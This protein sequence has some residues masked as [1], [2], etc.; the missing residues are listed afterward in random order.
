[1]TRISVIIGC[2][3]L[4]LMFLTVSPA[5]PC[6]TFMVS[7]DDR[8]IVAHNLDQEFYTPGMIHINRRAE[9]KRSIS[10]YDIGL[11]DTETPIVEWTSKYGSVTLSILG[12]NL[13]DGGMNE[14]GLTVSE[15]GLPESEFAFDISRPAMLSHLWIQYQLDSFATVDEV[16]THLSDFNIE[17]SSTFSP[18]ASANYHLFVTDR[19]GGVAIIEFLPGGPKIYKNKDVPVPILC[20]QTYEEELKKLDRYRGIVG[21]LK[22]HM[23]HREDLRFVVGALALEDYP[24]GTES[25]PVGFGFDVLSDMQFERTKQWSV[26]YDVRNSVV[27]FRTARSRNISHVDLETLDLSAD[28]PSLVLEDI[29]RDRA[30][31][32]RSFFVDFTPELDRRT[33]ERFLKSLVRFVSKT[34]VPQEMDAYMGEHYGFDVKQYVDRALEATELVRS[35]GE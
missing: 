9:K 20:N 29:D 33:I 2:V 14:M 4:A 32:V 7:R 17:T 1:M 23:R 27:H 26:V 34:D 16:L 12:K 8:L 13:P 3:V 35:V 22:R 24:S 5:V 21:W 28:G 25:D 31:N 6:S 15:M 30:G 19:S 18:P 10:G 11:V